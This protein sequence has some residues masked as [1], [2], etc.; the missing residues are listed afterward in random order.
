MA[1]AVIRPGSLTSTRIAV[2][3]CVRD[4]IGQGTKSILEVDTARVR[5]SL[6]VERCGEFFVSVELAGKGTA[7]ATKA[8][9]DR[10]TAP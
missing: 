9:R 1:A 10:N 7:H 4:Q 6:T 8:E 3:L 5:N 2:Y